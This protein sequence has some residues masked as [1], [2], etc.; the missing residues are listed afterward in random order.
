MMRRNTGRSCISAGCSLS[1]A[2]CLGFPSSSP[3][4]CCPSF[5]CWPSICSNSS[6][7]HCASSSW[8]LSAP[9]PLPLAMLERLFPFS[10]ICS[11]SSAP[12]LMLERSAAKEEQSREGASDDT[13]VSLDSSPPPPLSLN[14]N[15][16][17]SSWNED[18][19]QHNVGTGPGAGTG[20][21]EVQRNWLTRR[22]SGGAIHTKCSTHSPSI[23]LS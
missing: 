19:V 8:G 22:R 7:S 1:Q 6:S 13:A 20:A 9:S 15:N 18:G 14:Y 10:F 21:G 11:L 16:T 12:I 4:S 17:M 5:S 2:A 23:K 3:L